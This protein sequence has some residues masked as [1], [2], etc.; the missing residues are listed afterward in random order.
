MTKDEIVSKV[1]GREFDCLIAK[2]IMG[3]TGFWTNGTVYMAYPPAENMGVGYDERF[4]IPE[5]STDIA[6]AWEV[7]EKILDP[8]RSSIHPIGNGSTGLYYAIMY[9][10]K[11]VATGRTA[12]EAI[13][14]AALVAIAEVNIT[15]L[16]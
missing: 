2:E 13:C 11:G 8:N 6:A 10:D 5:F 12:P 7:W 1:P 4:P 16:E 15:E 3:W 14:K 9:D